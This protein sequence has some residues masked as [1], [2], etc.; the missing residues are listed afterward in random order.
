MCI[1]DRRHIAGNIGHVPGTIEH[2]WHGSKAARGYQSRWGILTK[3]QFDPVADLKRNVWGVPE[4][5]G[6]KPE[7]RRDLDRYFRSRNEDANCVC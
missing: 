6:N 7:L 5:A 2:S 4:L 3:H 1:R